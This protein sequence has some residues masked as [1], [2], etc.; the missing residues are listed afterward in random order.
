M[1]YNSDFIN[2]P[3]LTIFVLLDDIVLVLSFPALGILHS[4]PLSEE[5]KPVSNP[6]S[7]RESTVQDNTSEE[8]TEES[9]E[10]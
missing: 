4:V 5:M 7:L 8:L 10:A 3:A 1:I 9:E 2:S 6:R